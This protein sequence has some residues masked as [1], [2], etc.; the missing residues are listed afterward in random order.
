MTSS[1]KLIVCKQ[2]IMFNQELNLNKIQ[3]VHN[4][5]TFI[6]HKPF[7]QKQLLYNNITINLEQEQNLKKSR[8]L[9]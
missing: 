7:H 8:H 6:E 1:V 2:I 3:P 9:Y 5:T 4:N